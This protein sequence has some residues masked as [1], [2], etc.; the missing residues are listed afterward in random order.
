MTWSRDLVSTE[1]A[2]RVLGV[3]VRHVRRLVEARALTRIARGLIDRASLD[4]YVAEHHGGRT[5][6]WAEP[7]AWGAIALLSGR[8]TPWLGGV[9]TSRLRGVLRAVTDPQDLG[10]RAR[11]RAEVRTF[12]GH[13]AAITRLKDD[14]VGVDLG[15]LGLAA[16][17]GEDRVDGYL[18]ADALLGTI[19]SLGLREDPGGSVT[20]RATTFDLDVVRDLAA[21]GRALVALDAATSLH[22]RVRGL[23]QRALGDI[24]EQFHT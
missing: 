13:P 18:A 11:A 4:R 15:A 19:G 2:A 6:I 24:L 1:E 14:L 8:P 16:G 17:V 9:Q 12:A 20:L 23:G 7:T 5:R 3:T 21:R 22:P 10:A